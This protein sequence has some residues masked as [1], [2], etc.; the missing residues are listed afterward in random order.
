MPIA[1]DPRARSITQ[2]MTRSLTG[3]AP[4]AAHRLAKAAALVLVTLAPAAAQSLQERVEGILRDPRLAGCK[5]GVV[6]MDPVSE[7]LLA[8]VNQDVSL[9]PASNMKLL[10]SGAAL[11][12]LGKG[13]SF[14]TELVYLPPDRALGGAEPAGASSGRIVL[15]GSG[16]P[17]LADPKLLAEMNLD[18]ESVLGA[19]TG[20][21]TS[22]GVERGVELVVD[23][24]VFDRQSVHPTWPVQQLNRWYCAEVSGMNFHANVLNIFAEP[25]EPGRPPTLRLEPRAPWLTVRNRARSVKN[26]NQTAWAEREAGSNQLTLH[27]DVRWANDPVEVALQDNPQFVGQLLSD[28]MNAVG[29]APQRARIAGEDED[30]TGGQVIHAIQTPLPAVLARC[31]VD[32]HNLYAEALLKRLGHEVTQAPGSWSNGSA[33]LRMILL[34]RLGPEAGQAVVVADGSGMS[35]QNRVTPRLLAR[36]LAS[37]QSDRALAQDFIASLPQAAEEGTLKRRFA[38]TTLDNEVRAKTGY[39]TGVSAISG[40]V[41]DRATGRRVVFVVITNDKPNRVPLSA[42]REAEE[43]IVSLAD[44]W[45]SVEMG[46]EPRRQRTR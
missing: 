37:L 28:R 40:Y 45:L 21:M 22:A 13:F 42:V 4:G 35:R 26:G 9:I 39:L 7:K 18:A 19:W 44:Q 1:A 24:R 43:R 17:A 38:R 15:K 29:I 14:R 27:G 16:D 25:N 3:H 20:A 11:A 36:W 34:E 12:V 8:A 30:L 2:M 5:T 46:R 41:I 32:S 31:N 23:D 33:V 6:I 10:T